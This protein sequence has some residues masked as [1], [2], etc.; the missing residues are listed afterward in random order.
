MRPILIAGLTC[1][2]SFAVGCSDEADHCD[3]VAQTGCSDGLVCEAVVDGDPGCFS[4]LLVEGRVIDLASDD[5]L[6]GA[7]VVAVDVN[8]APV[9]A[10]AI[11]ADDGSYSLP[12]PTTRL[13][14]SGSY[15]PA[16]LTLRADAHGYQSFPAGL[17]QA[18]PLDTGAAVQAD[19][20]IVLSSSITEIGLQALPSTAGTGTI[21]GE[22]ERSGS[23]VGIL[24][25]AEG[26]SGLARSTIADSDGAYQIFNVPAGPVS[27]QAYALGQNYQSASVELG[28][29]DEVEADL[30]LSEAEVG[31]VQGSVQIVNAPGGSV[32]T[33]ILVV[34]STFDEVFG[35]GQA[36]PSLRDPL[37]GIAADVDGDYEFTGVPAGRYVVLAAFENDQ[38]VRDPDTS[39][40]GTS[41]LHIEVQ[42]GQTTTVEGFKVT[43][44]LEILAPGAEGP[45]EVGASPTFTWVDDSSED[46]YLVE[47]FNAFGEIIWSTTIPGVSGSQPSVDYAGPPLG[48]GLYYQ[49]RV[50]SFKGAAL[51]RSEDLKGVFYLP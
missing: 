49:V 43:E 24:V 7:R 14:S 51:S 11:S 33:V 30:Q 45:E 35:R 10:V 15:A 47:V 22:V 40:G 16:E 34:E 9:S 12:V 39:I 3:L 6:A 38:L 2:L 28:D 18:L 31:T 32:T 36:I 48:S 20:G 44:A 1:S 17:R 23:N 37:P 29:G 13:D 21:S 19:D 5:A 8:G 42:P 50:T 25:V 26:E 46:E 41:T 4:P 27:V